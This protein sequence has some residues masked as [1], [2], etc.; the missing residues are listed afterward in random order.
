[1]A[2]TERVYNRIMKADT[3]LRLEKDAKFDEVRAET[4]AGS[5][6]DTHVPRI[7]FQPDEM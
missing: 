3:W 4:V 2:G 1:M 6:W 7:E 5:T